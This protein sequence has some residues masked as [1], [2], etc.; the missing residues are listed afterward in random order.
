MSGGII[1]PGDWDDWRWGGRGQGPGAT[2]PPFDDLNT[3]GIY[4]YQFEN[5]DILHFPELQLPHDY[6]EG[7]DLVPHIHWCPTTTETYTGTWTLDLV[8]WLDVATGTAIGTVLS[9]TAAFNTALTA[10]QMQT[11]AFSAVIPGLNR[12]ISSILHA[13]LSLSLSAGT[14]CA[15]AGIDAHYQKDRLGSKQEAV[16]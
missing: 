11:Q 4:C 2:L 15:L 5:G 7:S 13:K 3:S 1:I 14:R 12:K 8:G 6:L 9:V 16:K 10:F